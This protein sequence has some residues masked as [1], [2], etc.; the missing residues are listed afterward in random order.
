MGKA[1]QLKINDTIMS[2]QRLSDRNVLSSPPRGPA[3]CPLALTPTYRPACLSRHLLNT[4]G[5]H[6]RIRGQSGLEI[7][8]SFL[9][10]HN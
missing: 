2:V 4:V 5:R 1:V 9:M 6:R 8:H 7:K 10:F 3:S